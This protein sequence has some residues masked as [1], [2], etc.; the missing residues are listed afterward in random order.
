MGK[1][2]PG[3]PLAAVG[4]VVIHGGRVLLVRRR[5]EPNAGQW[6]IPGG[7]V[8]LGE[9]LAAAAE[10]EVLEE[11]GIRVRAGRPIYAFDRVERDEAGR[12]RH[13]YVVVDVLAE[14]LAGDPSPGDDALEARWLAP[15]ELAGL[16][17]NATT[18][19]LL[20]T[21]VDFLE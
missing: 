18:L 9:T 1:E 15:H 16:P 3:A 10:R 13:H 4:A 6:A 21:A 2:Y 20:R 12:V 17:V 14:Y 11:S 7:S 8:H 19:D 5:D